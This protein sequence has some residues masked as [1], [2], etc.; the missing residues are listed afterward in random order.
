LDYTPASSGRFPDLSLFP[1]LE[2][3]RFC[4][5]VSVHMSTIS[6]HPTL[7]VFN[8]EQV[9][10]KFDSVSENDRRWNF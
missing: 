5:P 9:D 8:G 7:R 2:V 10:F 3:V 1:E 6:A 4:S